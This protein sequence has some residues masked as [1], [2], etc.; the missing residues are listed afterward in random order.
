MEWAPFKRIY[1]LNVNVSSSHQFLHKN[2]PDSRIFTDK[3]DEVDIHSN[4]IQLQ[5]GTKLHL[6]WWFKK[7]DYIGI[8]PY[9][10]EYYF[11]E[12]PFKESSDLKYSNNNN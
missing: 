5:F 7:I 8:H 2:Y 1:Y 4:F 10:A 12:I 3:P 6:D 9:M 11:M